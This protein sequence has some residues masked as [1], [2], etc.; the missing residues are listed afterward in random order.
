MFNRLCIA[1]LAFGLF[2]GV[3]EAQNGIVSDFKPAFDSLG[4][5]L[6]ERTGVSSK[7][8]ALKIMKRGK[9]LDFYLGTTL[10]DYPWREGDVDW[11]G[12]MLHSLYPE[13]YK[14]YSVGEL[15]CRDNHLDEYEG[16]A[17]DNDGKPVHNGYRADDKGDDTPM[18]VSPR[19]GMD[20]DKGLSGRHIALWQSHG[21]YY[22]E[23][24]QRWEWQRACLFGTVED[25]YTQSYV[26]PFLIPMLE[27]AGAYVMTPRERDTQPREII[28]DNDPCFSQARTGLVRGT[29][30][31]SEDGDWSDAGTGF[32][33]SKIVYTGNDNPF[34]MGTA[35]KADVAHGKRAKEASVRWTPEI[36][37]RGQYAVYVSYK[38]MPNSTSHAHYTVS[39]KGGESEFFV[40]QKMGGGTWIYLGTFEF[41]KDS[42][43]YVALDNSVIEDDESEKGKVVTADAVKI[44]GGMGKIARG[45]KDQDISLY[46]TS[47]L[48]SFTEG[49]LYWMQWAGADT[50]ITRAHPDDYTNDYAD[51]GPWVRMMSGGSR[52]NPK[53]KGKGIPFDLSLAFHTDAGTTPNDSIVGTLAIYTSECDGSDKLQDGESRMNCRLLCDKVQSQIVND[54]RAQYEPL[55]SRRQLWDKSYSES[56]TTGVPAMLLEFLSHQNFADMKYGLDPQ[57]RFSVSRAIYKGILKYLSDRYGC[58]YAVEPLP[59]N[60]FSSALKNDEVEL[61]WKATADSLEPTAVSKGFILYTRI[62][63]GAFDN[64]VILSSLRKASGH[65][66]TSVPIEKG[67]IYSFKIEA[68]NDGGKSFPSQ[69]LSAGLPS[70]AD[71]GKAVMIVNNFDR[72]APPTWFDTPEYGGL[73]E[74]TDSGMPYV[75]SSNTIGDCYQRRRVLEWTDDDNPGFGACYSDRAGKITQGNT[76]DFPYIHGKAL[77]NGGFAFYSVSKEAFTSDASLWKNSFAAD[78]ICGKQ[79]TTMQGR[80]AMPNR[81]EVFPES[82]KKAIK[83]YTSQGKDILIS[84]SHIGTDVWDQIYPAQVDSVYRVETQKFVTETLGYK[85]LTGFASKAASTYVYA[86]PLFTPSSLKDGVA[87]HGERNDLLYNAEN[88]DA[89]SP[90]SD[91]SSTF[92]RYYDTETSAAVCYKAKGYKVISVGFPLELITN[93]SVLDAFMSDTMNFFKKD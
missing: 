41:D 89:L 25:M 44:G 35:R 38:T 69:I 77:L 88:V 62:D 9:H 12:K 73:D 21:R 13:K 11:L 92:L 65:F 75:N 56:R 40:N 71:A 39:H 78:I 48:P 84:G 64:G 49:A 26:L 83:D 15:F 30:K 22:E 29:G 18:L 53:E 70:G 63:D 81:H 82:V 85:W 42:D 54:V 59:V 68:F 8:S 43:N 19:H 91:K 86:N 36:S 16:P 45:R 27:R 66:I 4:V 37:E 28:V 87:Y 55:W 20:F 79:V 50:T 57:F 10:T 74:T 80:G 31:Y 17:L 93:E 32:S 76:F 33:D 67:H 23:K 47:G 14:D 61:T 2:S 7:P 6:K 46:K 72:V 52:V 1:V 5:L 90:A 58:H 3:C 24:T 60:S 34:A 51:R